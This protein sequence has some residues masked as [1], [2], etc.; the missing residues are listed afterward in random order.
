VLATISTSSIVILALA[1]AAVLIAIW[2]VAAVLVGH[3]AERKNRSFWSF[4]F[5][6]LARRGL[7]SIIVAAL[8]PESEW[9]ISKGRRKRCPHCADAVPPGAVVCPSC[10]FD[11]VPTRSRISA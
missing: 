9:M 3:A 10:R 5:I 7:A 8:P 6:A 11:L 2:I 1:G 4:F